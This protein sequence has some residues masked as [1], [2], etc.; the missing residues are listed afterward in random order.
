[1]QPC[2]LPLAVFKL[3]TLAFL[4]LDG[5]TNVSELQPSG[6][7]GTESQQ[8]LCFS[9]SPAIALRNQ[10]GK[11]H[12]ILFD[13]MTFPVGFDS[14]FH[15]ATKLNRWLPPSFLQ[16]NGCFCRESFG[17]W[18]SLGGMLV[19]LGMADDH[20]SLQLCFVF[21]KE[22]F[23][24]LKSLRRLREMNGRCFVNNVSWTEIT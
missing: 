2:E 13:L 18:L 23:R 5:E 24:S 8:P 14:D 11:A 3:L 15:M 1:M 4:L 22:T 7:A 9:S 19:K 6:N 21:V 17:T 12:I 16:L 10:N 20:V